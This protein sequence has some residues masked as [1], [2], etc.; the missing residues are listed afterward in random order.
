MALCDSAQ[1]GDKRV[2][3]QQSDEK[4]GTGSHPATPSYAYEGNIT[5][6]GSKV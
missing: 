1:T 6:T 4:K 3:G 2:S 5:V